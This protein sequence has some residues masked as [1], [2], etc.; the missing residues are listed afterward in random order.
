MRTEERTRPMQLYGRWQLP[1]SLLKVPVAESSRFRSGYNWV[2]YPSLL[3]A[4][5][6]LFRVSRPDEKLR[7]CRGQW[8]GR[9]VSKHC[10]TFFK[11]AELCN[12]ADVTR[13]K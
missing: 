5:I 9:E 13:G 8:F 10:P 11:W 4:I 7:M 12:S 6:L 1:Q 3:H 2:L